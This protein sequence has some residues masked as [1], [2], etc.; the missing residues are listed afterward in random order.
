MHTIDDLS[1]KYFRG[2]DYSRISVGLQKSLV[3]CVKKRMRN[4][5]S[6]RIRMVALFRRRSRRGTV[7]SGHLREG[8]LHDGN[9]RWTD[10]NLFLSSL[11]RRR[12]LYQVSVYF[13]SPT[14]R[15][16]AYLLSSGKHLAALAVTGR[17]PLL[18]VGSC[19]SV[20]T[21]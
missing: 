6:E 14:Y 3:I 9:S 12:T 21:L 19:P 11:L 18:K 4:L 5:H 16:S 13:S 8:L 1:F 7:L 20:N 2:L 15:R 10:S 17:V